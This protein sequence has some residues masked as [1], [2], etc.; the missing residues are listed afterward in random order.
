MHYGYKGRIGRQ[1]G[2]ASRNNQAQNKRF[3]DLA[4][5]HNLTKDQLRKRYNFLAG[6]GLGCHEK[7][8]SS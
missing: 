8:Y 4:N 5:K 7:V 1:K 3:R 2:N 6:E